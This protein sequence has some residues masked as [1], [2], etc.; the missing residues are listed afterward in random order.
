L[1]LQGVASPSLLGYG[2]VGLDPI[3]SNNGALVGSCESRVHDCGEAC[4]LPRARGS[5]ISHANRGIRG[6]LRGIL[7]ARV[8]CA[9]TPVPL[10]FVV[11]LW[12]G[13]APSDTLRG[14][15]HSGFCDP[16]RGLHG[17]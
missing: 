14:P 11:V 13:T 15:P 4:G 2:G 17:N 7:R 8:R 12:H 5:C 10:L 9:I 3:K 6:G 1:G 16:V